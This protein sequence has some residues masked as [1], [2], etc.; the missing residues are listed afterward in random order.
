MAKG[1]GKSGGKG[2]DAGP[3]SNGSGGGSGQGSGH[4]HDGISWTGGIGDDTFYGGIG[5]DRLIGGHGDDDLFGGEGNDTLI[6]GHGDD[7]L[8]GGEGNDRLIGGQGEDSLFGEDGSD[9]LIGGHGNDRLFGGAGDDVLY[10]DGPGHGGGSGLAGASGSG[11]GIAFDDYL[12][13]GAGDDLLHG[14]GGDDI[15]D[16]GAGTDTAMY[17][18]DSGDYSTRVVDGNLVITDD[19]PLDGDD[20]TDTLIDVETLHFAGDGVTASLVPAPGTVQ[21]LRGAV[22]VSTHLA[23]QDAVDAAQAGDILLIGAGTFEEQV[24][25]NGIDHLALMGQGDATIIKA[26]AGTLAHNATGGGSKPNKSAMI[27]VTDSEG[28]SI[29]DLV[30]DGDGRGNHIA[31]QDFNGIFLVNSSGGIYDVAVA[32][33]R[34][35]YAN[36]GNGTLSGAQRGV[37]I[38]V[39]NTDGEARDVEVKDSLVADFQKNGLT[40]IGDGLTVTVEGNTVTGGG[41]QSIIAQNGIQVSEGATGTISDNTVEEIGYAGP[42]N[43]AA[44]GILVY[45]AG[46]GVEVEGNIISGPADPAVTVGVYSFSSDDVEVSNNDVSDAP[47]GLLFWGGAD[48]SQSDNTF[49]DVTYNVYTFGMTSPLDFDGS[50]GTD[51]LYGSPFGDAIDAKGGDDFVIGGGGD[52]VLSGGAGDDYLEGGDGD[53]LFVFADGDGADTIADFTPGAGTDDAIDLTGVSAVASFAD[54]QAR[55][56]QLGGDTFIDLDG[57]DSITLLGVNL[58]DLD[59]DDFVL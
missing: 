22:I 3:G 8:F 56:V 43:W 42:G 24:T 10:G 4:G 49:T 53:D 58:G 50:S 1:K 7:D 47:Y 13:G 59:A 40:F 20:G 52:D 54:V 45:A 14:G 26:P 57:G 18:G 2:A 16:G 55:A 32:G 39:N 48:P 6:G 19:E 11:S 12:N 51:V 36:P 27:A 5:N 30:V 9:R 37:A 15:L 29:G 34:D 33:I 28:I 25:I 38:L 17:S 44:S 35:P 46:E 23:I 21:I 41:A 31:G